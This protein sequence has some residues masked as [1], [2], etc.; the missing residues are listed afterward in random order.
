[1]PA[2][3]PATEHVD[4]AVLGTIVRVLLEDPTDREVVEAAWH[5]CVMQP[6]A[7]VVPAG[8]VTTLP[9]SDDDQTRRV[10][11]TSLTQSVTYAAIGEQAG[12]FLMLHAG[13]L[14][15][16]ESGAAVAYV[17]PGGTGKTTIST[18]L[19][20]GRGYVTDE[21][22]AVGRHGEIAPYPKPLSTRQSAGGKEELAPGRMGLGPCAAPPWIAGLLV[23]R[24]DPHH[25]GDI[26]VTPVELLD[27]IALLSPEMSALADLDEPLRTCRDVIELAGGVLQVTYREAEQLEPLVAQLLARVRA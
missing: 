10:A 24:R 9:A 21:T 16:L 14:A 18:R 3:R 26:V 19:G 12:R 25:P 23:L 7:R 20:P 6:T 17:A 22:V 4:L 2:E 8:R 27:A 1:M 11:L 13:A 5:L 15:D